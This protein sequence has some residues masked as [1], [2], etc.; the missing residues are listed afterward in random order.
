MTSEQGTT[1]PSG[2]VT[3]TVWALV[4]VAV[5]LVGL[6]VWSEYQAGSLFTDVGSFVAGLIYMVVLLSFVISGAFI[7]SRMPGN[8]IG[9]LLI[10]PGLSA[11]LS[12]LVNDW[13]FSLDPETVSADPATWL[14]AWFT[15]WSWLLLI[16]PV[17]HLL[18]VFP[19]GRLLSPRWRW[20][21][22]LEVAMVVFFVG[23]VT[24]GREIGLVDEE[25]VTV[26]AIENP[27]GFIPESFFEAIS[28]L[29]TAGLLVLTVAGLVALVRRFRSGSPLQRQQLKWPLYAVALFG[30][31][32]GGTA[33]T[34]GG[35]ESGSLLDVLFAL[36][37]AAIP[38]SIA[39]AVL[40]YRL[41]DLDRL[42][43]RTVAYAVVAALLIAVYGLIVLGLGS[44]LGQD[45][46]LAV[47]GATLG[48][49]ALFNPI[50]NRVRGWVDRRFNRSR[51]DAEQV[52]GSFVVTLRDQVDTTGLIDGWVG[53]V[54]ETMQPS[55]VGAW[56]RS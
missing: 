22:A 12:E 47:A 21:V 18:L 1:K 15:S 40:R 26:W 5:V 6:V 29:W 13:L 51:Y 9:W 17:F 56:V 28:G 36:S 37:L 16:Y 53:V 3:A 48:A 24:F 38:I 44:F 8:I 31:T 49:A 41:Y 45:N 55:T 33:I 7:A 52:I 35:A 10:V 25:D 23:L 4:G 19:D 20:V 54:S 46:P 2:V 14:G 11:A 39:I 32:Y 42:V 30:I 50:R 43:S 27:I 34:Q